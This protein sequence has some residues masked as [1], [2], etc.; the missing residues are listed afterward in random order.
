MYTVELLFESGVDGVNSGGKAHKG[1]DDPYYLHPVGHVGARAAPGMSCTRSEYP[2][3]LYGP[4]SISGIPLVIAFLT[5][6]VIKTI[7]ESSY[8]AGWLCEQA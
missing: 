5:H 7:T 3:L 2:S 1:G 4:L 6:T 8:Q